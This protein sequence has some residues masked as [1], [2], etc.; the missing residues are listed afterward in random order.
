MKKTLIIFFATLCMSGFTQNHEKGKFLFSGS[1]SGPW[2]DVSLPSTVGY[3]LSDALAVTADLSL[4]I[5]EPNESFGLD[6]GVRYHLV[7]KFFLNVDFQ[8]SDDGNNQTDEK[9]IISF[10]GNYVISIRDWASI[11]PG[12]SVTLEDGRTELAKT[13]GFSLYF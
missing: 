3:Y 5:E 12:L 2:S 9:P 8:I 7:E 13:I 10:G 11:D 1:F 4:V 6:L